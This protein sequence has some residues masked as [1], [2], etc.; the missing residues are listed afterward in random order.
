MTAKQK[1]RKWL[2]TG[3]PLNPV[4]CL[5]QLGIYRLSA[6][7]ME[8]RQDLEDEQSNKQIVC[9]MSRVK[10]KIHSKYYLIYK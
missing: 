9:K 5:N 7:I 8:L 1:I 4:Q 3:K 6:R 10:G 2:E